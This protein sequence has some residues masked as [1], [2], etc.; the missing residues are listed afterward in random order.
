MKIFVCAEILLVTFS[1][2]NLLFEIIVGLKQP[3][4][5]HTETVSSGLLQGK[6]QRRT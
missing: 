6:L 4:P 1:F 2:G 5:P 3:P